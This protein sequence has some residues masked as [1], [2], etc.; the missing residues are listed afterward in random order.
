MTPM[1]QVNLA[2]VD[3]VNDALL[4]VSPSEST[5]LTENFNQLTHWNRYENMEGCDW[6]AWSPE[7]E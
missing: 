1:L 5:V 3:E 4:K 7:F 2:F 6:K